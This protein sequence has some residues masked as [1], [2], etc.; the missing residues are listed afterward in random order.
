MHNAPF[1]WLMIMIIY[2]VI[3]GTTL[4]ARK[5]TFHNFSSKCTSQFCPPDAL[6]QPNAANG[7]K[8]Q[9]SNQKGRKK[10]VH[11]GV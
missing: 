2:P 11:R 3:S 6:C 4:M 9:H 10:K 7:R 1:A 8:F 5:V